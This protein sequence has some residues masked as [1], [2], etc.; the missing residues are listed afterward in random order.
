[1]KEYI[2]QYKSFLLF[3][4]KFFI[5]YLVLSFVYQ[6]YLNR[7]DQKNNEVDGFTISVANQTKTVLS[8]VDDQSYTMPHLTE[9]SVKLFYKNKWVARIIEGCNALSVMILFVSFIIAFSGKFKTMLLF[10]LSGL[11]I[12]HIFNVLRIALLSMAVYHYNEYQDFL[13][14]VIFPLFIYGVVFVLWVIWVNK[15]SSYAKK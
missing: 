1:M 6:S 2:L 13:H 9:P 5:T 12:I 15:Y 14:S 3:L 7:F 8:L 10:I 4:A 11:V